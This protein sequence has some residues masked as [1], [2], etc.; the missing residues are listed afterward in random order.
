MGDVSPEPAIF[1]VIPPR[2]SSGSCKDC[3]GRD[4][5]AGCGIAVGVCGHPPSDLCCSVQ[6]RWI[7]FGQTHRG[8]LD[9]L[10]ACTIASTSSGPKK[11]RSTP[12]TA[13]T[14]G[15]RPITSGRS[16]STK[17]AMLDRYAMNCAASAR[18]MSKLYRSRS[19]RG[20]AY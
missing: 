15:G 6:S 13:A 11:A 14:A 7:E 20:T 5:A 12:V 17:N 16:S 4:E 3:A 9:G 8:E 18:A 10:P 19:G 2:P 1:D